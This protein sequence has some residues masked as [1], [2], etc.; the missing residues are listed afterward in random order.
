MSKPTTAELVKFLQN[1]AMAESYKPF[2]IMFRAI[3]KHLEL[4][5]EDE[6]TLKTT[7]KKWLLTECFQKP[8]QEAYDLAKS[9]WGVQ[10]RRI[11]NSVSLIQTIVEESAEVTDKLEEAEATITAAGELAEKYPF[12]FADNPNF[13]NDLNELLS[14]QEQES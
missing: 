2:R 1:Q 4:E 14:K 5:V 7:F 8:T 12:I 13:A 10:Q 6:A 3:Y 9:A 11:N